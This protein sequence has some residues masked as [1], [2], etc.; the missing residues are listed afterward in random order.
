VTFED[1][2]K[3]AIFSQR[4]FAESRL[5]SICI[6]A[7]VES[8]QNRCFIEC[9]ALQQV[10]FE[11]GSKLAVIDPG[12]FAYCSS[13]PAISIPA[14]VTIIADLAFQ[15]CR[16][17][18]SISFAAESKLATIGHLAFADCSALKSLNIP[19]SV[20]DLAADCLNAGSL[21]QAG[22]RA[23]GAWIS[24]RFPQSKHQPTLP[25]SPVQVPDRIA[26]QS[27]ASLAVVVFEPG[28]TIARIGRLFGCC[29]SLVKV[30][31]PASLK[32]LEPA[33]FADLAHLESVVFE[34]GS[35]LTAIGPFAFRL[36]GN[37][38]GIAIPAPVVT[39]G[40]R[41]FCF[42]ALLSAVTFE[43]GSR[44]AEIRD[45]AF[46]DC[47]SLKSFCLPRSVRLV[48]AC[49]FA[50][51][52]IT[53]LSVEDGNPS[54]AGC[55]DFLVNRAD[56]SAIRYSGPSR[57]AIVPSAISSFGTYSF[58]CADCAE[59]VFE[60]GSKLSRLDDSAFMNCLALVS[61][62]LP[63]SLKT[64]GSNCFFG[65]R[66]LTTVRFEPNSTFVGLEGLGDAGWSSLASI[67]IPASVKYLDRRWF[68]QCFQLRSVAF[69]PHS[70][71][72]TL[73]PGTFFGCLSLRSV[74]LP[75]S[76]DVIGDECF[77]RCVGLR[78]V[79]F[80]TGSRLQRIGSHAFTGCL[81]LTAICIP[82]SV[83]EIGDSGF[84]QAQSGDGTR[85]DGLI[86]LAT[87]AFEPG[88]RL[89]E[90]ASRLFLSA[91]ALR[92][93]A[94]P[95]FVKTLG[96]EC[97]CNCS[98]LENVGFESG[99]RLAVV[100]D[101]AF[102][103]CAALRSCCFPAS[104]QQLGRWCF[105][106]CGLL[107]SVAFEWGSRLEAIGEDAFSCCR[108]LAALYIRSAVNM[109]TWSDGRNLQDLV[110]RDRLQIGSLGNLPR[111]FPAKRT[112]AY[113]GDETVEG[114]LQLVADLVAA[115]TGI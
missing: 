11:T 52:G 27:C 2:T 12:A 113:C 94:I 50:Q 114:C 97:F 31:L 86:G 43:S 115:L 36:C 64:I 59:V 7:S 51:S 28:S 9:R 49:S 102:R 103:N 111:L 101:C 80:E 112:L 8:L 76:L 71:L 14:G 108:R 26:V 18:V 22:A 48:T 10:T 66:A 54:F 68:H 53:H 74:S 91:A 40:A 84:G 46:C 87:V 104:V 93:I 41:A 83:A 3:I 29:H 81:S 17:L 55:G 105:R 67:T 75:A 32:V 70:R 96:D 60:N 61:V 62:L 65:C 110:R 16:S 20:V 78:A 21:N 89:T 47:T 69:E 44:L 15:S 38:K 82:A 98:L 72:S 63:P 90:I 77:M 1:G 57:K 99:S 95:K 109:S 45:W 19:A 37:L 39:I 4:L 25:E 34:T 107:V 33:C 88:S 42:C 30:V 92:T 6:P 106:N 100:G 24:L 85:Q 35:R 23:P 13:L 79:T 58:F 56:F 73:E 5:T